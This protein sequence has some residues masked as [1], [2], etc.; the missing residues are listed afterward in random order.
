MKTNLE[1]FCDPDTRYKEPFVLR[2]NHIAT[3]GRILIAIPT[4]E[5][6]TP[7]GRLDY[8]SVMKPLAAVKEWHPVSIEISPCD[9]CDGSGLIH[10]F[11]TTCKKCDGKG[12]IYC[13]HC[14][15]EY[16]CDECGGD[17]GEEE[18]DEK[19]GCYAMV[20]GRRIATDLA[21]KMQT[22]G[23][24]VVS[25]GDKYECMFFKFSEGVGAVM[26]LMQ[27]E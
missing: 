6:D 9:E 25:V 20:L 16:C 15:H 23:E 8:E 3:D 2:G 11:D 17:G 19:C 4:S 7:G 27:N 12:H 13:S 21:L 14:D 22:L 5:T 18:Y 1:L 10:Y 24:I 26:P